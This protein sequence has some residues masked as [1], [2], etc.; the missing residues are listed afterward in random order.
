[1]NRNPTPV[2]AQGCFPTRSAALNASARTLAIEFQ[3]RGLSCNLLRILRHRRTD[4]HGTHRCGHRCVDLNYLTRRRV[5]RRLTYQFE[6]L[7]FLRRFRVDA[8]LVHHATA[9]ILCGI[10][11]RLARVRRVVMVEHGLHQL[12][13]RPDYR[14]SATR[15][16]P[17]RGCDYRRG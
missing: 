13:D 14:R 5:T 8:L 11:A 2:I 6:F 16:L 12:R 3:R 4:P 10:P 7:R 17:L 1:M 9:L 15:Y